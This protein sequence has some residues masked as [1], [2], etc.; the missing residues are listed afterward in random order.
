MSTSSKYYYVSQT[1]QLN[2]VQ[3]R[4]TPDQIRTADTMAG[5]SMSHQLDSADCNRSSVK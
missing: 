2:I 1:I 3:R 4:D 5:R